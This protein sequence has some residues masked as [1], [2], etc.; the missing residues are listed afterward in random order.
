MIYTIGHNEEYR[1]GIADAKR[2]H[3]TYRKNGCSRTY[4]GGWVWEKRE[5][6][7]AWIDV[8]GQTSREVFGIKADWVK[9]TRPPTWKPEP[10]KPEATFRELIRAAKI[11]IL[12]EG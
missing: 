7:Q 2:K 9:D 3:L 6:A 10:G 11:V 5:Q 8:F 1:K 12:E 4:G